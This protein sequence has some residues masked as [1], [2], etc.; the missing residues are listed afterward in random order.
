MVQV[1]VEQLISNGFEGLG[2]GLGSLFKEDTYKQ[3]FNRMVKYY[4]KKP[5]MQG[6]HIFF[7]LSVVGY[8]SILEM[9]VVRERLAKTEAMQLPLPEKHVEHASEEPEHE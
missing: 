5:Q 9:I 6:W 2:R 8:V 4:V 3:A 1:P 7:G